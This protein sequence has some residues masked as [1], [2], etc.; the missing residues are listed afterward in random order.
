VLSCSGYTP[1]R[2]WS[3][4]TRSRHGSFASMRFGKRS[5]TR[6]LADLAGAVAT[7]R[8]GV[9][10]ERRPE[11]SWGKAG[12]PDDGR[13]NSSVAERSRDGVGRLWAL[14]ELATHSVAGEQLRMPKKRTP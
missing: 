13:A 5:R 9:G 3:F 6:S 2:P 8:G 12:S 4:R 14:A 7:M 1:L 11:S 10:I